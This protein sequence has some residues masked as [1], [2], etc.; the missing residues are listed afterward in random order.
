MPPGFVVGAP[1]YA[2]FCE[3]SGLRERIAARLADLDVEDTAALEAAAQE[4]RGGDRARADARTGWR[5]AIRDAYAELV[6]EDAEAPVAVR[7]SATAE[8]TESASF[9]GHER[10][11][12]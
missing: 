11:A 2:A 5:S 7:S 10:D 12:S 8:D 6:G 3:E 9:A 4:V 1:A